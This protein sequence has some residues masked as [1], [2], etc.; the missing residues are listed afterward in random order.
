MTI[1]FAW[2]SLSLVLGIGAL[3]GWRRARYWKRQ[4]EEQGK[5]TAMWCDMYLS[6]VRGQTP[7]HD[8][9][10]RYSTVDDLTKTRR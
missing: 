4:C 6:A 8:G 7:T 9:P 5:Q 3:T 1:L 10:Y 2:C